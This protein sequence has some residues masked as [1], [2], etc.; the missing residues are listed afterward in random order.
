MVGFFFIFSKKFVSVL[1]GVGI[2]PPIINDT[3]SNIRAIF[4]M[5]IGLIFRKET[6]EINFPSADDS[7]MPIVAMHCAPVAMRMNIMDRTAN[8]INIL[9]LISIVGIFADMAV[10]NIIDN[11]VNPMNRGMNGIIS[12]IDIDNGPASKA[13]ISITN[14]R[15]DITKV[16]IDRAYFPLT[17]GSSYPSG[18]ND[19]RNSF[20]FSLS[21]ATKK[22]MIT[23][24]MSK[25]NEQSVKPN[26]LVKI[27]EMIA[28]IAK[29]ASG[30]KKILFILFFWSHRSDD[31]AKSNVAD[32]QHHEY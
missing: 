8:D 12:S 2:H 11:I 29:I 1:I 21:L 13:N 23:E 30:L 32:W 7:D 4:R 25:A 28:A 24:K 15:M 31:E 3:I 6:D 26:N 19:N 14:R 17:S 27:E 10:V 16:E 20:T 18:K 5:N 22:V 9:F